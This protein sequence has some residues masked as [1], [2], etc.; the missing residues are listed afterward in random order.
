MEQITL[1][2]LFSE[3]KS[4]IYGNNNSKGGQ[5]DGS[6]EVRRV[7]QQKESKPKGKSKKS[8]QPEEVQPEENNQPEEVQPE[9]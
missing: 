9:K 5:P 4:K 1:Q 6:K 2:D 7:D 3:F 8:N